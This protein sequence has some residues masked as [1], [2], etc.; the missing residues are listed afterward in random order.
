M[1]WNLQVVSISTSAHLLLLS[2]SADLTP[3]SSRTILGIGQSRPPLAGR[4]LNFIRRSHL[5]LITRRHRPLVTCTKVGQCPFFMEL[6]CYHQHKP[7]LVSHDYVE[8]RV[9]PQAGPGVYLLVWPLTRPLLQN[10]RYI[11]SSWNAAFPSVTIEPRPVDSPGFSLGTRHHSG[12]AA[13]HYLRG[14][15]LDL[16]YTGR[17]C[18]P[19][20]QT[21]HAGRYSMPSFVSSDTPSRTIP[22]LRAYLQMF[23]SRLSAQFLVTTLID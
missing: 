18:H 3:A 9:R 11:T 23:H 22:I 21:H 6:V 12:P 13:L 4:P 19:R 7:V 17:R 8:S 10:D 14:Q 5:P 16:A 1:T 15:E 20:L 2:A